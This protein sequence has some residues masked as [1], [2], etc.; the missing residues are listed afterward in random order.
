MPEI[1]LLQSVQGGGPVFGD[2]G[3]K[4]TV[5]DVTAAVWADGTRAVL[6]VHHAPVTVS[7]IKPPRQGRS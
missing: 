7:L 3:D 6:V 4:L 1:Q 2:P 5:E